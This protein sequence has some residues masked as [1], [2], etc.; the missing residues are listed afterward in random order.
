MGGRGG[1]KGGGGGGPLTAADL[2]QNQI[3]GL[4]ARDLKTAW[5]HTFGQELNSTQQVYDLLGVNK[6]MLG[7]RG[8]ILVSGGRHGSALR[9][10]AGGPE[11]NMTRTFHNGAASH[12]T[13]F[14]TDKAQ[15]KGLGTKVLAQATKSYAQLGVKKISLEATMAGRYVWPKMGF[16]ASAS[17]MRE[18]RDG[19]TS[20]LR[21]QGIEPPKRIHSLNQIARTEVNGRK[22][23]K[24][25]LLSRNAPNLTH[26]TIRTARLAKYL[27][28][29]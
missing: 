15:G 16:R 11:F 28:G 29:K 19:F 18:Y 7:A 22:L 12:D 4:N 8:E 14:L 20:F 10:Y 9:I 24:E 21:A 13:F 25:Y 5:K 3:T 6:G 26:M 1:S 17:D 23:G 27:S 2:Q